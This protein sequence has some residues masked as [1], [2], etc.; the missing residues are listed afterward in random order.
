MHSKNEWG[1]LNKVVVGNATNARVPERDISL[2]HINYADVKDELNIPSGR[3]PQI[4]VD[5]ANEDLTTFVDF[6][7]KEGVCHRVQGQSH[8]NSYATSCKT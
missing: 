7:E 6:L 4:V 1:K 5:E 2:R 3:Y 8:C